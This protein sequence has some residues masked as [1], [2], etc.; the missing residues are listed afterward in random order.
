MNV[1]IQE[2]SLQQQYVMNSLTKTW[3]NFTGWNANCFEIF[4]ESL[5]F[6]DNDGNVNLAYTGRLDGVASIDSLIQCSFNYFGS[7]G[8]QKHM[9]MIKPYFIGDGTLTPSI[10]VN[11]DFATTAPSSP[12]VIGTPAGA[13]W[14]SGIWDQSTWSSGSVAFANWQSVQALGT[15]LSV[16]MS[17]NYGV[18][19]Q[20]LTTYGF[21]DTGA[22]DSAVFDGAGGGTASGENVP[23]LQLTNFLSI[24]QEGGPI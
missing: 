21:F 7:P 10:S 15:T 23:I 3:C 20:Q 2:N 6:G 22:F 8:R 18:S 9:S 11:V 5:Y 14:D 12:V 17:V 1:P 16:N 24:M 19:T 4:N 13:V